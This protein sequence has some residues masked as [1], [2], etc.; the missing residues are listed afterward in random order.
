MRAWRNPMRSSMPPR[1]AFLRGQRLLVRTEGDAGIVHVLGRRTTIGRISANDL[2]IDA[3]FISRHHA[4]VLVTDTE[5]VVED[6]NSTNG[7]FVNN[8][9]VARHPLHEGDLLTI[10]KTNFRYVFKPEIEPA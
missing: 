2:S 4:V 5:T 7:V 8:V 1:Q 3:D 10:G 9:R 6:L